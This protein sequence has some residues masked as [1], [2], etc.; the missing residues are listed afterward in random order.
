MSQHTKFLLIFKSTSFLF[1]IVYLCVRYMRYMHMNTVL[2]E[3]RRGVNGSL[4]AGVAGS[5]ELPIM[6]LG[7]EMRVLCQE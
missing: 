2:S 7:I 4:G 6:V 1:E 3:V 5:C